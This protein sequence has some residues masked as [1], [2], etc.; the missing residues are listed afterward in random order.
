MCEFRHLDLIFYYK[1]MSAGGVQEDGVRD[2]SS[3]IK[4]LSWGDI[5]KQGFLTQHLCFHQKPGVLNK[6]KKGFCKELAF[7][8]KNTIVKN[9]PKCKNA[10]R[11]IILTEIRNPK[12]EIRNCFC[13]MI[14]AR[15]FYCL[16][17]SRSTI[18][19]SSINYFKIKY[20]I[21]LISLSKP[22]IRQVVSNLG[23][24]V[25]FLK[26]LSLACSNGV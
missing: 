24:L 3:I 9:I 23:C 8:L 2:H 21:N 17:I 13:Q 18:E 22:S 16:H 26:H 20:R 11:F 14:Q 15:F 5:S 7:S 4:A 1:C 19:V 25:V 10:V 12:S 6:T